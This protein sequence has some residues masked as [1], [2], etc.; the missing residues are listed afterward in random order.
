VTGITP[1]TAQ[2]SGPVGIT[3]L[4]G[5]GFPSIVS[6]KLTRAGSLAITATGIT[7]VSPQKIICTF[8]LRGRDTGAWDVVVTK[9]D[10]QS[11][12][13]PK[14]FTVTAQPGSA[15]TVTSYPAG[16]DLFV[17]GALVG[18]TPAT[19][20]GILPGAHSIAVT[21]IG[22]YGYYSE[23][24]VASGQASNVAVTLQPLLVEKGTISVRSNPAGASIILDGVATGKTTPY[25]FTGITPEYHTVS[26]SM[27][28]YETYTQTVVVNAGTT[29]I[30]TTPWIPIKPDGV[31]FISSIPTGATIYINDKPMGITDTSLHLKPGRYILKLTKEKYVDNVSDFSIGA[32]DVIQVTKA[33]K[34]PG[35]ECV[36]AVISVLAVSLIVRKR[37]N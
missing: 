25:D 35:F 5:S 4:S 13:L 15:L 32:G 24:T 11:A 26:V 34:T 23:I 1:S 2:N 28:G 30:V 17:D 27:T 21:K 33:L 14:G 20:T 9:P 8:D 36:L 6:V 29:V 10:G 19:F 22:Y 16:A 12:T 37:K 31:V 3:D 7:V 18:K